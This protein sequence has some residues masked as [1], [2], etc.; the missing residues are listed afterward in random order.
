MRVVPEAYFIDSN[1]FFASKFFHLIVFALFISWLMNFIDTFQWNLHVL[2]RVNE[3]HQ[4]LDRRIQLP[5]YVLNGKH[6]SQ[7]NLP[8]NYSRCSQYSDKDIFKLIDKDTS[9]FLHLLQLHGLHLYL[10]QIGLR[11]FPFP[12]TSVLTI[13]KLNFL[14]RSDKLVCFVLVDGL[15]FKKLIIQNFPSSKEI[16]YP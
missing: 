7:C 15:L 2:Q 1:C 10:E 3:V 6:C 12:T 13:L 5:H 4:L 9:S 14:H 16:G 8:V 11:I